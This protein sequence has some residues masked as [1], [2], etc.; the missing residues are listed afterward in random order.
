[1]IVCRVFWA[2]LRFYFVA[3]VVILGVA[4]ILSAVATVT[5]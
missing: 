1:M 4:V 2:L 3:L 5:P